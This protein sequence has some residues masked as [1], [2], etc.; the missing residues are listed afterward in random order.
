MIYQ[1]FKL[2]IFSLFGFCAW[3]QIP[4]M[5]SN[6]KTYVQKSMVTG[7]YEKGRGIDRSYD[8]E[9]IKKT[10]S[11]K[12]NDIQQIIQS[13]G[14]INNVSEKTKLCH[15]AENPPINCPS[16][17]A[18]CVR[19]LKN[20]GLGDLF[21]AWSLR[22]DECINNPD[23]I[24][25]GKTVK[26]KEAYGENCEPEKVIRNV[27]G[28]Q[29]IKKDFDK[30]D[31]ELPDDV[32]ALWEELNQKYAQWENSLSQLAQGR[33]NGIEA[34]QDK[35]DFI[36]AKAKTDS[37]LDECKH[38]FNIS[39]SGHQ[40]SG[41]EGDDYQPL[42]DKREF[43]SLITQ[44]DDLSK[45][46]QLVE[47]V[48]TKDIEKAV[49]ARL[50]VARVIGEAKGKKE[51]E[52]VLCKIK[53][54]KSQYD[55]CS[56]KMKPLRDKLVS[57]ALNILPD[58]LPR[59]DVD[60]EVANINSTLGQIKPLCRKIQEAKS[61]ITLSHLGY[62]HKDSAYNKEFLL[63]FRS[64]NRA[65][66]KRLSEE[67]RKIYLEK[68]M[69]NSVIPGM[70]G[71]EALKR[72]RLGKTVKDCDIKPVTK[73]DVWS[74]V[75]QAR[76]VAVESINE[77]LAHQNLDLASKNYD[78]L[79]DILRTNPQGVYQAIIEEQ[80]PEL[81]SFVCKTL[82]EKK[83]E[84][85]NSAIAKG[86]VVGA[87]VASSFIPGVG[88]LS[89]PLATALTT[90]ELV[91][92]ADEFM[93]GKADER[94][95][96]QQGVADQF[97][98]FEGLEAS[99][100]QRKNAITNAAIEIALEW[101]TV[102]VGKAVKT[103]SNII[104]A[105]KTRNGQKLLASNDD[106]LKLVNKGKTNIQ[107]Y[108]DNTKL[109]E[110]LSRKLDKFND[111]PVSVEY[112]RLFTSKMSPQ[113]V[114]RFFLELSR[115]KNV[116]DFKAFAKNISIDQIKTSDDFFVA[117][118]KFKSNG[119]ELELLAAKTDKQLLEFKN[120][121]QNKTVELSDDYY[122]LG[123]KERREVI[124]SITDGSTLKLGE[125]SFK[126][127]KVL[128]TEGS[129][130]QIFE[131]EDGSVLRLY[132][133]AEKRMVSHGPQAYETGY[134]KL[135]DEGLNIPKVLEADPNGAWIRVE[136]VDVDSQIGTFDN[137]M[138]SRKNLTAEQIKK[139]DEAFLEF[140][141]STAK[142]EQ[143]DD[144]HT[145]QIVF[146]KDG[147]WHYLDPGMVNSKAVDEYAE[148][149]FS[150]NQF[151]RNDYGEHELLKKA[152]ERIK[153]ERQ[154]VR[155]ERLPATSKE[156]TEM[157]VRDARFVD[158]I[159]ETYLKELNT[160]V[161]DDFYYGYYKSG[162][163]TP[164]VDT[165]KKM[166]SR[167]QSYKGITSGAAKEIRP[168]VIR[169]A[170]SAIPI[171][172]LGKANFK[173]ASQSVKDSL[174]RMKPGENILKVPE[175]A[176]S[177]VKGHYKNLEELNQYY[178]P[179]GLKLNKADY[180]KSKINNPSSDDLVDYMSKNYK[181]Q[182]IEAEQLS[183][184]AKSKS[185]DDVANEAFRLAHKHES[186]KIL[187]EIVNQGDKPVGDLLEGFNIKTVDVEMNPGIPKSD[188][189][190][191][192]NFTTNSS[193]PRYRLMVFPKGKNLKSYEQVL[194]SKMSNL[195]NNG[196]KMSDDEFLDEVAEFY[197][198]G[199]NGH[200]FEKGNNSLMMTQINVMLKDRGLRHI[201]HG[202]LDFNAFSQNLD[203]FK[204]TFK[205]AILDAQK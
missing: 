47:H 142:Y 128:S 170:D 92:A 167:Y 176:S 165:L 60:K 112:I 150:N 72:L 20:R 49:I 205:E 40:V 50:Y 197:H 63:K 89:V 198:T 162:K 200:I 136:K 69:G 204:G 108:F 132:K 145:E 74:A 94:A 187:E 188:K 82:R 88:F 86:V 79:K 104:S 180:F 35:N 119:G 84:D 8:W 96:I 13:S 7:S 43:K 157:S 33:K 53:P 29:Y 23:I 120:T 135:K 62:D 122:S 172:T 125:Q 10:Y 121:N 16:F 140:S 193:A 123:P 75:Y 4:F 138:K 202:R 141:E 14:G 109:P 196:S 28:V 73:K 174:G 115:F 102:G 36:A 44:I 186:T 39:L 19:E 182:K 110:E 151:F 178:T 77:N 169:D 103:T 80:N 32:R 183:N 61:N 15:G 27:K 160:A 66:K 68:L 99:E 100:K 139:A 64:D 26:Y 192:I 149:V 56:S 118:A 95:Y 17:Q 91:D 97:V 2:I 181:L 190:K 25:K 98:N 85:R 78:R 55:I 76:K 163:D 18:H 159:P 161:Y 57:Q 101:G 30:F 12:S 48:A 114:E 143:F 1:L 133:G 5:D 71:T 177:Q 164:Y 147:K 70:L 67:V 152:N 131:L 129:Y 158:D 126:I 130:N 199:I 22:L 93:T 11:E 127:K 189:T 38:H 113:E 201:S 87:L 83:I 65:D 106:Y 154:P 34:E 105:R 117:M 175:S 171:H 3:S 81:A 173:K 46:N 144:F 24:F 111:D 31:E 51:L 42:N 41:C 124:N 203:D 194:N 37:I 179:A 148:S 137:Y 116:D 54:E 90:I 45:S 155:G 166:H 6:C 21:Q 153:L 52:D 107:K 184:M 168:G 9:L 58:N 156:F 185:Y 146:G 59:F 195:K 134:G 191:I